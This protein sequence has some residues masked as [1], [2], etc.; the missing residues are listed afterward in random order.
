MANRYFNNKEPSGDLVFQV[1]ATEVMRIKAAGTLQIATIQGLANGSVSAPSLNFSSSGNENTGLYL[2]ATDSL[3]FSANGVAVGSYNSTGAWTLGPVAGTQIHTINGTTSIKHEVTPANPSTGYLGFY[4]K[5]DNAVY[6]KTSAGTEKKIAYQGEGI[7]F[8]PVGSI[9]AIASNI[10][11]SFPI[12]SSGTVSQGWQY[13][14]GAAITGQTLVGNTP[15]LT[16]N[17]FLMGSTSSGATG[18]SNTFAPSGTIGGSQNIDHS[19][20]YSHTHTTDAQLGNIGL[21]HT[22][23]ANQHRHDFHIALYDNS[24]TATASNAAMGTPGANH[25]G[26]YRY[27]TGTFDG[28]NYDGTTI[29]DTHYNGGAGT[30][31]FGSVLRMRSTGDTNTST[32]TGMDYRLSDYNASHGHTTNSQSTTTTT[33][34]NTNT[35]VNGSNFTFTGSSAESRPLYLSVQY[36]IRVS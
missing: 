2:V 31:S 30:L 13:C 32:D 33:G 1:G 18:G 14:D 12:P 25:A 17:R 23:T 34:M 36:I 15:N 7:G 10:T 24:Y 19:H 35:V 16:G 6:T 5:S 3:G 8:N 20:Q 22:H 28:G 26:A 9:V 21:Y 27:S 29:N 4:A 11:N